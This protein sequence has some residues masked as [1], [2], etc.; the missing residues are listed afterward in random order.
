M[1]IFLIEGY[2]AGCQKQ[3]AACNV[4]LTQE[5]QKEQYD[6]KHCCPLKYRVGDSVLK[7]TFAKRKE[8]EDV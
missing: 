2:L 6:R 7:K 3:C 1:L 8:K 5:K 4:L